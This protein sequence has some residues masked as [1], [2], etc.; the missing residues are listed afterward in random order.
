METTEQERPVPATINPGHRRRVL[1]VSHDIVDTRMAG[2]GIRA[3][4]LARVLSRECDVTLAV[5]NAVHSDD[6]ENPRLTFHTYRYSDWPSIAPAFASADLVILDSFTLSAFP[7]ISDLGI[8]IVADLYDPF[9]LE[10]LN[11]YAHTDATHQSA[12]HY[13]ALQLANC[14]CSTGDYFICA[15]SRQRDW[16]L[17]LLQANGRI[18]PATVKDDPT[19]RRLI[20]VV[21]FG[22]PS[23]PFPESNAGVK[24]QLPFLSPDDR[25]AELESRMRR[26]R[27]AVT[28]DVS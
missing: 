5:P 22:L 17:G 23:Q 4:E 28:S 12:A 20:E 14:L 1:F 10:S 27:E 26:E 18:N 16:W 7:Q 8:P 3:L 9:P 2:P 19:L 13:H 21:P 11:I 25:A 24:E 15:N 6:R